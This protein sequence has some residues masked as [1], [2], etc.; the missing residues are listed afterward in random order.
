MAGEILA[1]LDNPDQIRGRVNIVAHALAEYREELTRLSIE[2][3]GRV[4]APD[5]PDGK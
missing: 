4:Q 3:H 2:A 1:R 5:K